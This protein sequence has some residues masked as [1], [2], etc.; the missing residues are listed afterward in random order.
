MSRIVFVFAFLLLALAPPAADAGALQTLLQENQKPVERA[1][2]K[3]IEPVLDT[4]TGSQL[5]NVP[6]FLQN[7]RDKNVWMRKE[8]KQFFYVMDGKA[9][10]LTLI[11]IDDA[12]ITL[13][14]DKKVM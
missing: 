9:K 11:D 8:D 10:P 12:T 13:S 3:T 2:R 1:S 7:W 5:Q 14:A 6:L 4:L